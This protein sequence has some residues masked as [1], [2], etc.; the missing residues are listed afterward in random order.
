MRQS[1]VITRWRPS[2]RISRR[3]MK[4]A[5]LAAALVYMVLLGG[6]DAGKLDTWVRALNALLGAAMILLWIR[7]A[8]RGID[9][10][11]A[12]VTVA[13][14]G[15]LVTCLT[16]RFPRES[17]DAATGALA[18]GSAFCVAR[19]AL[20][21]PRNRH[22]LIE[23]LATC[24]L[25]IAL[26]FGVA[27][28]A[29]WLEWLS[30]NGFAS[31][32]PLDLR[33]PAGI[34]RHYYAVVILL[35]LLLP[36]LV[37]CLSR[38]RL[39]YAA[40]A[41]IGVA[42]ALVVM[43][44]SRTVWLALTL[45]GAALALVAFRRPSR[46]ALLI[47]LAVAAA[48]LVAVW[49]GIADPLLRRVLAF[50]TVEARFAIWEE[51]LE[52][53]RLSPWVGLG[54]GSF[55]E[56]MSLVGLF[57]RL[58]DVGRHADNA[59]IQ[60]LAES[61]ILGLVLVGLPVGAILAL[62]FRRA[63]RRGGGL[64]R[65]GFAGIV[66]FVASA[67]TNNP[68]DYANSVLIV[69]AWAAL[70]V[71]FGAARGVAH[72]APMRAGVMSRLS[73]AG[74]SVVLAATASTL[75]AAVAYDAAA[76]RLLAGDRAGAV[77]AL[78][79]AV[80]LDPT[81]A[82]YV[83][84]LGANHLALGEAASATTHLQAAV[85]ANHADPTA[86][87]SLALSLSSQ[88]R[89]A[90]AI[91][92]AQLAVER[93]S[94]DPVNRLMLAHVAERGAAG[95]VASDALVHVIEADPW[96]VAAPS[97]RQSFPGGADLRT[98]VAAAAD[99]WGSGRGSAPRQTIEPAWLVG[100]TGRQDLASEAVNH[101][102]AATASTRAM[103]L[104]LGCRV[105]EAVA[106]LAS[107]TPDEQTT[108]Q[109]HTTKLIIGRLADD[110][111]IEALIRLAELRHP[112]LGTLARERIAGSSPTSGPSEDF[113]LYERRSLPAVGHLRFPTA[114]E[115]LSVWLQRPAAAARQLTGGCR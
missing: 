12:A 82:L 43:S 35:S 110:P 11:D 79:T 73:V 30:L 59:A 44:G 14:L 17:L 28:G 95:S 113:R 13:I 47:G 98:L 40:A 6:T 63:A 38:P 99:K 102:P 51:S 107:A 58:E 101:F 33:L 49:L 42:A 61:G 54:P 24:G 7:E 60:Q 50:A 25:A 48:G 36:A 39:R 103:V 9:L 32:P 109:Y 108:I 96:I 53:W 27:W 46:R 4:Q 66:L 83:R 3:T 74:G 90:E 92:A 31:L 37:V 105:P 8:R 56:A 55:S 29:V 85:A 104:A 114:D 34:H 76:G 100:L 111:D 62:A 19:R 91:A 10:V 89:H 86:L 22:L 78:G 2:H 71:P 45:T 64:A 15:F 88:G 112:L 41:A 69:I 94:E 52:A 67:I 106:M 18:Y 81:F 20:R 84:E 23:A 16:S 70:A 80:A 93:K 26:V 72:P 68:S 75:L 57:D 21:E 5:A 87:R 65:A 1:A 97:W 77:A 115:G